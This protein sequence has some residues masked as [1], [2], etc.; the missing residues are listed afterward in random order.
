MGPEILSCLPFGPKNLGGKGD[1]FPP[2]F[3]GTFP[4]S[5]KKAKIGNLPLI[6]PKSVKEA[7]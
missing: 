2:N 1:T 6:K 3:S 4:G 7:G 5:K